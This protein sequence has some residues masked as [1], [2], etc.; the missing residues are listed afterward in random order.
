M[1]KKVF[2]KV[3]I[4]LEMLFCLTSCELPQ[5][6]E[7]CEHEA[8][9]V[10]KFDATNHWKICTKCEKKVEPTAHVF[11]EGK[12][13]TE[14]T[15]KKEGIKEYVCTVC[16]FV[17]KKIIDKLEH[18]HQYST[19]WSHDEFGHWHAATCCED[20][21]TDFA[22]HNGGTGSCKELAKCEICAASYGDYG[23]HT[24]IDYVSNNDATC[25]SDGTKTAY[26]KNGCGNTNTIED[27]G[28]RINHKY[29]NP[30]Y[31]WSEDYSSVKATIICSNGC[32]NEITEIVGTMYQVLEQS[33]VSTNG[34]GKYTTKNFANNYF[35]VQT[36]TVTLDRLSFHRKG[37]SDYGYVQLASLPNGEK[38]QVFYMDL[39]N[40]AE[41]FMENE[42]NILINS[43][44][45]Y[46]I[47]E[48]DYISYGL[49]TDEAVAVWKIFYMQNPSYYW[50]DNSL[51]YTVSNLWLCIDEEYKIGAYRKECNAT[52]DE[53]VNACDTYISNAQNKLEK[54]LLIHDFINSKITYAYKEDGITPQDAIWAHNMIG[55]SLKRRGVCEA[56][57]KTYLYLCLLNDI[58]CIIVTGNTTEEHAWNL[59]ELDEEWYG[60][61]CTFDDSSN[62]GKVDYFGLSDAYMKYYNEDKSTD[63]GLDYLYDL[64]ILSNRA[65]ELVTLYENN[66][67]SGVYKNIDD[68]FNVINKL[69]SQYNIQLFRYQDTYKFN[70]IKYKSEGHNIFTNITPRTS[71]IS[72]KG[73]YYDLGDG[74]FSVDQINL[75]DD[76][77]VSTNLEFENLRITGDSK[78]KLTNNE[79][80]YSGYACFN[81]V[82]IEG[83]LEGKSIINVLTSY[84]TSFE[85][86]LTVNT[87]KNTSLGEVTIKNEA[88]ILLARVTNLTFR[89]S[90]YN[91]YIKELYYLDKDDEYASS[92]SIN[93]NIDILI[94]NIDSNSPANQYDFISIFFG[95][96]E[97]YPNL[98]I[99]TTQRHI[100]IALGG[101]VTT[102]VTDQFGNVIETILEE[103]SPFNLNRSVFKLKDKM[104]FDKF[105]IDYDNDYTDM[106]TIEEDGDVVSKATNIDGLILCNNKV[107]KYIGTAVEVI[108]P[109]GVV[110]IEVSAFLEC[111]SI[112]KIVL[113]STLEYIGSFAFQR[114]SELLEINIPETVK[115]IS[116]NA[117][118][119]CGKLKKIII[120]LSVETMGYYVFDNCDSLTIYCRAVSIPDLWSSG[121][122]GNNKNIVLGYTGN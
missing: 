70:H 80:T 30:F 63:V 72:I 111:A 60:V 40:A 59:I 88:N 8:G 77:I 122:N 1:F 23:A 24:F 53:M 79:I 67:K 93:G 56:Y 49:T 106:H 86:K 64:P 68:A 83:E 71:K 13:T 94:D 42:S 6:L 3:F 18:N 114:C 45:L 48:F 121:W 34:K 112:K 26:C 17:K 75:N 46:V 39:L 16:N 84:D 65:F 9:E 109:E 98:T 90:G 52:I 66:N 102:V 44:G 87:L 35:A 115:T 74:Y 14:P 15:D 92:V 58:D 99:G 120:P 11:D 5:I 20:V 28:T 69:N 101:T 91:V 27:T 61:D 103:V 113:P 100:L 12:V 43:D 95:S 62:L 57:A 21:K 117:F 19:E 22:A 41:E 110:S 107:Y 25:L 73:T 89:K 97:D 108:V 32:N 105:R 47:K 37:N 10:W 78:I 2:I 81:E 55:V 36:K 76:L 31:E 33:T 96:V 50:L 51:R 118:A 38:M 4:C 54:A 29:E 104:A 82:A 116:G 119:D 7:K 85:K